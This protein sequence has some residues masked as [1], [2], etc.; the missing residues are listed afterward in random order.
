M[1]ALN[2]LPPNLIET[3]LPLLP[4]KSLG[5]FKSVSKHWYSLIS[6]PNFIKTHIREYTKNN[7]NPNPTHLILV[8]NYSDY[9]LY[10]LDIKLLNTQTTPTTVAAKRMNLPKSCFEILGSCNGFILANDRYGNLRLVNPVVGKPLKVS[11]GKSIDG[12]FGF[13]YDSSTDDYKVISISCK[14]VSQSDPNSKFSSVYSLRN[15]S[16]KILPNSSYQQHKHHSLRPGVLVNNNL[17][18]IVRSSHSTLTIAAF[19]LANEE[20]HEIEFPDSIDYDGDKW[21]QL[22]S[23]G[24]KL[25]ADLW[26]EMYFDEGVS[27]LRV[28]EEYGDPK[29]WTK[30]C[31][32]NDHR[33]PDYESFAQIGNRNILLGISNEE[34]IN[35]II[36]YNMDK[37][38][39]THVTVEGC[40]EGFEYYGTYVESLESLERFR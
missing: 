1:S 23:L 21:Y 37:R 12:T 4:P 7:P 27:E 25:V 20:F 28:M 19:N 8:P 24:G 10:S 6:S 40:Q 3:I 18:W 11:G 5:R 33:Y 38:R 30:L 39:C 36:V 13:D 35:E 15:N 9:P 16:W 34:E 22:H 32:F 31:I 2:H 26:D 14:G 29:S 17:H